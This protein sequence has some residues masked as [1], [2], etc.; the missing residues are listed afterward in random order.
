MEAPYQIGA[1][2]IEMPQPGD[3]LI[4]PPNIPDNRFRN[5][6]LLMTHNDSGGSLA[7]CLNKQS[8]LTTKDI[9]D[10]AEV[11]FQLNISFPMF[12][13][14]P[15]NLSTVWMI[16]DHNWSMPGTIE[17][18]EE[19][20]MTSSMT[21]F[22]H[23]ADGDYPQQFRLCYGFCSWQ[24]EQLKAELSGRPPWSQ[25]HS[26]LVAKNPGPEWIMEAPVDELWR[27]TTELSSHQA[28]DDWL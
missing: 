6:V 28:V 14:G 5:S 17:I 15:I 22:A 3:L 27:L 19:W 8:S 18:N 12:W 16:H 24:P 7:L 25:R 1:D 2:M 4:A 23:L 9:F 10:K 21:M 11:D 13:G 20:S 26:W